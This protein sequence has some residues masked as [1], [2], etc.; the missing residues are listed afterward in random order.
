M[1][2]TASTFIVYSGADINTCQGEGLVG[3]FAVFADD[4]ENN[5]EVGMC[6]GLE[7]PTP[8]SSAFVKGF[9]SWVP[10]ITI[11][12]LSWLSP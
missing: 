3:P 12:V 5:G 8:S 9:D 11:R 4:F 1:S 7:F 10:V 6:D 2:P